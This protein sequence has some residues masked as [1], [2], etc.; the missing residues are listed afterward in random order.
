MS[1]KVFRGGGS[2]A[3]E[4]EWNML[5]LVGGIIVALEGGLNIPRKKTAG[6][7]QFG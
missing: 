2:D 4:I 7:E 6:N 3:Q 5:E 1:S